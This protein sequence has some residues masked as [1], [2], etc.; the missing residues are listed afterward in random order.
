M[1]LWWNSSDFIE[2]DYNSTVN[3]LKSL[4]FH[5]Q[6]IRNAV[7]IQDSSRLFDTGVIDTVVSPPYEDCVRSPLLLSLPP[8]PCLCEQP[9]MELQNVPL[10]RDQQDPPRHKRCGRT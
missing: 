5:H 1:D 3:S 10:R 2:F 9:A 8:T 7:E 6:F 4:E